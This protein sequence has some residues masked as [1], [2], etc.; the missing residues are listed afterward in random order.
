MTSLLP[1]PT[2]SLLFIPPSLS[3]FL[4]ASLAF[5]S[6]PPPTHPSPLLFFLACLFLHS[7]LHLSL[8]PFF[9][10]SDSQFYSS[11]ST[12]SIYYLLRHFHNLHPSPC[13]HRH[14]FLLLSFPA[15]SHPLFRPTLL[16]SARAR[17]H[18]FTRRTLLKKA[19]KK[20]SLPRPPYTR[21]H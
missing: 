10:S 5:P 19:L 8:S 2:P 12:S 1:L 9:N 20:A 21:G 13:T 18:P 11:L 17:L 7:M 15:L 16:F 6:P 3:L 4:S 14:K